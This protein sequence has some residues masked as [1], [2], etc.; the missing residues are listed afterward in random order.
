MVYFTIK[1]LVEVKHKDLIKDGKWSSTKAKRTL[2]LPNEEAP[3]NKTFAAVFSMKKPIEVYPFCFF[4]ATNV[5][6]YLRE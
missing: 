4:I 3:S 5:F 2:P 6:V 1:P